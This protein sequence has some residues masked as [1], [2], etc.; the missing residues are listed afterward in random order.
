MSLNDAEEMMYVTSLDVM[1]SSAQNHPLTFLAFL[2]LICNKE[3]C[4][5][6]SLR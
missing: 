4:K 3:N 2:T 5:S 6:I 1:F